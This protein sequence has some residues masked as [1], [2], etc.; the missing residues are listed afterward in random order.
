MVINIWNF[1]DDLLILLEDV[2]LNV[3]L[4]MWYL[5]DGAPPHF[6]LEVRDLLN[7]VGLQGIRWIGQDGPVPWPPRSPDLNPLDFC[8]WGYL[9]SEV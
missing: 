8:L 5:H 4:W 2:S 3:R 6:R 1:R 9:K 7:Q